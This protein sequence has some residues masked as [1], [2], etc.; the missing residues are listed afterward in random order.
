MS[1]I[2]SVYAGLTLISGPSTGSPPIPLEPVTLDDLK[3]TLRIPPAF[4]GDDDDLL[5]MITVGR[6]KCESILRR[7]CLSQTWRL[8]LENWPGRDYQNWPNAFSTEIARY[9]H[10]NSIPLPFP[11][12]QSVLSVQ[13]RDSSGTLHYMQPANYQVLPGYTYN[14]VT[15]TEPGRI[16]LPF[17]MIWPTDI[18]M[19]GSPIQITYTCGYPDVATFLASFE[20]AANVVRAVK[21][22]A[23][24]LY[25]N[26]IP[27]S[28]MRRSSIDA[29]LDFVM[30]Q[31]LNEYRVYE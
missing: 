29:G 8:S 12:L 6:Q 11:P 27:P 17:S 24:Y 3:S 30:A 13:Y 16:V 19:P 9:Y 2:D 14:V 7:A 1:N 5:T 4:T 25:E 22:M 23:G 31:L 26:K 20:G 18:L 28:E 10:T 15:D 21:M